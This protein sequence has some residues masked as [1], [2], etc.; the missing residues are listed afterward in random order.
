MVKA[1]L[2]IAGILVLVPMGYLIVIATADKYRDELNEA[3]VLLT[4]RY[5]ET[6]S[7]LIN[8]VSDEAENSDLAVEEL[9][10]LE[11]HISEIRELSQIIGKR[12]DINE[13]YV[14]IQESNHSGRVSFLILTAIILIGIAGDFFVVPI[15]AIRA[16]QGIVG[17]LVIIS[18]YFLTRVSLLERRF[19]S[20]VNE[21]IH[22]NEN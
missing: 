11:K 6:L 19:I 16:W 9:L 8:D 2:E 3:K 10:S 1:L 14:G 22:T 12:D 5:I 17:L 4:G 7:R 21:V 20:L 13:H 15:L 18:I